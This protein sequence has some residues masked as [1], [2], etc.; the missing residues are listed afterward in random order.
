[1]EIF[2][3]GDRP[4][5]WHAD[6]PG[7][8]APS[9]LRHYVLR[10][11]RGGYLPGG[12]EARLPARLVGMIAD[13]RDRFPGLDDHLSY[14]LIIDVNCQEYARDFYLG[15]FLAEPFAYAAARRLRG[16]VADPGGVGVAAALADAAAGLAAFTRAVGRY[17][18]LARSAFACF[19]RYLT[20]Y[21]GGS[22]G[23]SGAFMPSVRLVELVLARPTGPYNGLLDEFIDFRMVHLG[24][25]RRHLPE[26]FPGLAGRADTVGS[27]GFPVRDVLAGADHRLLVLRERIA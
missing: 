26:A 22:R 17:A 10:E 4:P 2:L 23:A 9:P 14:E 19:R 16:V 15:H 24:V 25:V 21:S 1:M 7:D 3:A 13:L 6:S 5:R 27:G 18:G 12:P 8:H 11:L 20:D